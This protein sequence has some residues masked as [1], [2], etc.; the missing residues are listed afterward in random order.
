MDSKKVIHGFCFFRRQLC[1]IAG[2]FCI[3]VEFVDL[4]LHEGILLNNLCCGF[5]VADFLKGVAQVKGW[6]KFVAYFLN[7]LNL[8]PTM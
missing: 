7:C 3:L 6:Q 2:I 1:Q 5:F 4:I 8:L